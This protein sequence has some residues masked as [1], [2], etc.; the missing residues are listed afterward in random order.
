MALKPRDSSHRFK[1]SVGKLSRT[2]VGV[3]W[4]MW[5]KPSRGV[6]MKNVRSSWG[7][8]H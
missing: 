2:W 8:G 4:W 1:V 6:G 5:G 3:A 7:V